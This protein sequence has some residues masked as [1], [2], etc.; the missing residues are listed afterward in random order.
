LVPVIQLLRN[1]CEGELFDYGFLMDQLRGY[2]RPRDKVTRMLA[3]GEIVRVKKGLY[4]FGEDYRRRP[5][6]RAQ[7]ANLIYGPSYVSGLYALAQYDL[8]P[9]R[10][11]VVTSMT[12]RRNK[13]FDTP[14]GHFEYRYLNL[15]RYSVGV[16]WKELEKGVH[17]FFASP[18][19]AL[20]DT[21]ATQRDLQGVDEMR[22]HIVENLRIDEE[23]LANLD[24]MRMAKIAADYGSPVVRL[25]AETVVRLS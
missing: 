6:Q 15:Q 1:A 8:I 3:V 5:I 19:K 13:R 10:V 18:E 16:D 2:Q 14:F 12:A 25:L 24:G 17:C 20:A 23:A 4:V 7:L 11:E 9:E 21:V 22:E